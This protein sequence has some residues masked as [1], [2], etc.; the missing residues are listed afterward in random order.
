MNT[1][2]IIIAGGG[3]MGTSLVQIF[4]QKGFAVTLYSRHQRVP[5]TG[6]RKTS[7]STRKRWWHRAW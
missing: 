7:A 6:H 1:E 5:L 3:T 2:H 4:A